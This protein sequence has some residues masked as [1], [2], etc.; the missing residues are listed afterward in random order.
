MGVDGFKILYFAVQVIGSLC[1]HILKEMVYFKTND[2]FLYKVVNI[3][4]NVSD[5]I[6][7]AEVGAHVWW[8][9]L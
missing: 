5:R 8:C 9:I 4:T 3:E 1:K 2:V 7:K 6:R